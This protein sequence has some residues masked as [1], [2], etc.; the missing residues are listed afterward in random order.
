MTVAEAQRRLEYI[1]AFRQ[2]MMAFLDAKREILELKSYAERD[3][4]MS[5]FDPNRVEAKG[6]ELANRYYELRQTVARGI[7]EA[8]EIT[9]SFAIPSQIQIMPPRLI[10]GYSHTLNLYQAAI[11][12]ELPHHYELSPIKV[13]DVIDQTVF[14]SERLIK[15]VSEAEANKPSV[16]SKAPGAVGRGF[17]AIFKTDT[18]KAIIKWAIIVLVLAA[19]LRLFGLPLNK[20]GGLIVQW[21]A[22]K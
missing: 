1:T 8:T 11:E 7:A 14:A 17:T 13:M 19:I 10:G 4:A 5:H 18:D 9:H 2:Q 20:V 12:E 6:R 22:K 21:F 3:Y 16:I 15:E